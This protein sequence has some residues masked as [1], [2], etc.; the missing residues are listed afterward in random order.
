M[1]LLLGSHIPELDSGVP[2]ARVNLIRALETKFSGEDFVGM[3]A[4]FT[5]DYL[6]WLQ[7]FLVVNFDLRQKTSNSKSLEVTR[8]V[9]TLVL[10]Q[11]IK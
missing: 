9:D 8:I 2:T 5:F 3:S 11:R 7:S 10:I 1:S 6:D 4:M